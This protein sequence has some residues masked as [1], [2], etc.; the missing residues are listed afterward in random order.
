MVPA[1][2]LVKRRTCASPSIIRCDAFSRC[3][4]LKSIKLP[5]GLKTIGSGVFYKCTGLTSIDLPAGL[6]ELG[7]N[8]FA[9]CTGITSIA[10]P[11][12]LQKIGSGAFSGCGIKRITIPGSVVDLAGSLRNCTALEEVVISPG[13]HTIT[14]A[15]YGDAGLKRVDI[16]D[17][18]V[19]IG[20]NSFSY[21]T[22]LEEITLPASLTTLHPEAFLGCN[23][24]KKITFKGTQEQWDAFE[25]LII[26]KRTSFWEQSDYYIGEVVC[27]G[28]SAAAATAKLTFNAN[29]GTVSPAYR[30]IVYGESYGELPTPVNGNKTFYGWFTQAE[31]VR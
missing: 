8:A 14:G 9:D 26:V 30:D 3:A 10:L 19:S 6:E 13:V 31:G 5:A 27:L 23:N 4:S 29:G 21:C 7:S 18:V 22:S 15:F 12:G 17:T 1:I 2:L 11:Q 20:L 24:L 28:Q 16:P 25:P